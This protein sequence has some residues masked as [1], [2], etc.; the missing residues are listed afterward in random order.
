MTQ[1]WKMPRDE[2]AFAKQWAR[3]AVG[4]GVPFLVEE[5]N[6]RMISRAEIMRPTEGPVV[7]HGWVHPEVVSGL[8]ALFP[9]REQLAFVPHEN[10]LDWRNQAK[11]S[12]AG[13]AYA[14]LLKRLSRAKPQPDK[15]LS[16]QWLEARPST[17]LPIGAESCGLIWSLLWLHGIASPNKQMQDW[18]RVLAKQGCVFFS[19]FGPDTAQ[20]LKGVATQLGI[21]FP[22]FVDMHDLGDAMSL[23]GFSDPVME[24][25]K[26]TLTYDRPEK[27]LQDWRALCGNSLAGRT[28]GLRGGG[29]HQN[30][31]EA[32]ETNRGADGKLRLTLEVVYGH[33]W[34]VKPFREG[35]Q[36]AISVED[37]GGRKLK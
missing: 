24:M 27:L 37:I 19:C 2:P 14:R 8:Q 21:E 20:E 13:G 5:I 10:G 7:S 26:L 23:N 16:I 32:I 34:K 15:S 36:A 3:R 4:K 17:H 12:V 22:D 18:S 28:S 33:A 25:E 11:E 30:L 1:P 6:R 35:V 29:F 31:L 9:G